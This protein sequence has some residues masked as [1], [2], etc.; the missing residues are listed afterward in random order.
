MR[1]SLLLALACAPPSI[2]A[3]NTDD[4][5]DDP[6]DVTDPCDDSLLQC[7]AWTEVPRSVDPV[8]AW[9][10]LPEGFA[11]YERIFQFTAARSGPAAGFIDTASATLLL[12]ADGCEP[13]DCLEAATDLTYGDWTMETALVA[14]ERYHLV[15]ATAAPDDVYALS[16]GCAAP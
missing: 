3:A 11:G 8:A 13:T 10:C 14:G 5:S 4:S 7:G 16:V 1:A 15:V 9:S 2:D 12:V 6:S